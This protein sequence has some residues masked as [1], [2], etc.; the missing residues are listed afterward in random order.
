VAAGALVTGA[1]GMA[2]A[3]PHVVAGHDGAHAVGLVGED[4]TLVRSTDLQRALTR[5]RGKVNDDRDLTL[6]SRNLS[7]G[8][9]KIIIRDSTKRHNWHIF[10]NGVDKKTTV[11]GTGRWA[12]K[13]RLRSGTYTV[14]CDPHPRTMRFTLNVG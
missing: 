2:Q 6:S 14:V 11:S 12:W 13:V 9:Y 3:S 5:L 1:L 4:P 7:P 10:G 8:R